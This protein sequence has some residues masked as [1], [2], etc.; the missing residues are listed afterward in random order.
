MS[1]RKKVILI[2]T[3]L[4]IVIIGSVLFLTNQL[5]L[6]SFL[7]LEDKYVQSQVE[8]VLVS[9][10]E[11]IHSLN[12]TA[13]DW[14]QWDDTYH[15]SLGENPDYP[16]ENMTDGTF[17]NLQWNFVAILSP[18]GKLLYE[19][20]YDLQHNM[21][22][23]ALIDFEGLYEKHPEYFQVS[24]PDESVSGLLMVS[25]IPLILS[26]Q[27][28]TDNYGEKEISG[29]FITGRFF[30][31]HVFHVLEEINSQQLDFKQFNAAELPDE[32][33]QAKSKIESGESDIFLHRDSI[34][35]IHGFTVIDDLEGNPL[36][37]LQTENTRDIYQQGRRAVMLFVVV[38]ILTIAAFTLI[39]LLLLEKW[40]LSRL[41]VVF[42]NIN[43]IEENQDLSIRIPQLGNDELANLASELNSMMNALENSN[44]QLRHHR[45]TLRYE[46][47]HDSLTGLPNRKYFIDSLKSALK[48]ANAS[49]ISHVAVLFIDLDRFKLINDSF[50]HE[51]GDQVLVEFGKRVKQILRPDDMVARLGGDEFAVLLQSESE[52][53]LKP[54]IVAERIQEEMK[55]PLDLDGHHLF[56]SASIGIAQDVKGFSGTNLLRNAD[57]AM[58]RAKAGGRAQYAR[59][60]DMM[61][62]DS[63]KLLRIENDLRDAIAHEQFILHYQP[64]I[65]LKDGSIE[66]VE[67]LVRWNHPTR[68]LIQP[69]E[70]IPVA[71]ETGLIIPMSEWIFS[72]ACRQIE[73]WNRM[74]SSHLRLSLNVSARMLQDDSFTDFLLKKQQEYPN[75]C[76]MVQIEITE[77]SAIADI[78]LAVN[79]LKKITS[80]G[81]QIAIDDFGTGHSSLDYLR[82]FPISSLKIDQSFIREISADHDNGTIPSA[83][84]AMGHALNLTITAE[85]VETP[86][87]LQFIRERGCDLAQGFLFSKPVEPEIITQY[88]RE[89]RNFLTEFEADSH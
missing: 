23:N 46:S 49:D 71:E 24:S 1:L 4:S 25:N 35:T 32:F 51:M 13:R 31:Q 88:L 12:S 64:I 81:A 72:T 39:V 8:V 60:D 67:T 5:I 33:L 34:S 84:I 89:N 30:N 63:S 82:R 17:E 62:D 22:L 26:I 65:S 77:S 14:S 28:I 18:Q 80:R 61:R 50:N 55:K 3:F 16:A 38:L 83:V 75:L 2:I 19:K 59:Y 44:T 85:G 6:N 56:I 68:G 15:F 47:L 21:E 57:I 54:E 53:E 42:S 10:D 43:Q 66:A 76:G 58:Y 52:F 27:P 74:G 11:D 87:Q 7:E 37:I 9:L 78:D 73:A 48:K 20:A 70:F 36:F 45:E 79:M 40:I 86:A 29:S 41:E 69:N